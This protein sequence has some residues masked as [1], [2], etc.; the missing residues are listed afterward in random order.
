MRLDLCRIVTRDGTVG[1]SFDTYGVGRL[2]CSCL[3]ASLD[4]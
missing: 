4:Q 1:A 3:P 2:E